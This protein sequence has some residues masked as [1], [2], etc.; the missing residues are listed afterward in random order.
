MEEIDSAK[1]AV[2]LKALI[3]C[4]QIFGSSSLERTRLTMAYSDRDKL[5]RLSLQ[6]GSVLTQCEFTTMES[7]PDVSFPDDFKE[8]G[9]RHIVQ[10]RSKA[11]RDAIS[12]VIDTPGASTLTLSVIPDRRLVRIA[13]DGDDG[14]CRV[15][16]STTDSSLFL[17]SGLH[18]D[19][20]TYSYRLR[21]MAEAF[22]GTSFAHV[23]TIRQGNAGMAAVLHRLH[24]AAPVGMGADAAEGLASACTIG[25]FVCADEA[26]D[27]SDAGGA[28]AVALAGGKALGAGSDMAGSIGGAGAGT[29]AAVEG[30]RQGRAMGMD[31]DEDEEEEEEEAG[32]QQARG[33][34]RG[35]ASIGRKRSR[36][37]PG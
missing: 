23:T 7:G 29:G 4:L 8:Q 27:D 19:A 14:L 33:G 37:G 24:V 30:E 22:K 35:G 36:G 10:C 26:D 21:L 11:L 5:F 15:D 3:E 16:L 34:D 25:Y 12:D 1:F 2:N 9:Q 18:E 17:G 32:E 13:A 20:S 6:D 28:G 31:E